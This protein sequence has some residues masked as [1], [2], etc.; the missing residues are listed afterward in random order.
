MGVP[1]A[2]LDPEAMDLE[3]DLTDHTD[4]TRADRR[5]WEYDQGHTPL[6]GDKSAPGV[7]QLDIPL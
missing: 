5:T 2:Y 6:W 4:Q 1:A 7:S 3:E